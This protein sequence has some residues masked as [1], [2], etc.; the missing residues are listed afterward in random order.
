MRAIMPE[1]GV[2]YRHII[3]ILKMRLAFVFCILIVSSWGA[4]ITI[5][6]ETTTPSERKTETTTPSE[7]KT[8]SP[9]PKIPEPSPEPKKPKPSPEPKKPKSPQTQRKAK[10]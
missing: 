3:Y 8:K 5:S 7:R 6:R 2:I 1:C 9:E 10:S 4:R